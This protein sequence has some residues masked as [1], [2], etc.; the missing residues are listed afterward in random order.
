MKNPKVVSGGEAVRRDECA[1]RERMRAAQAASPLPALRLDTS[2]ISRLM[3]RLGCGEIRMPY[4]AHHTTARRLKMMH[5]AGMI[6]RAES[7][8]CFVYTIA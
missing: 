1:A 6:A 5:T 2:D 7:D 4:G 8:D 3:K